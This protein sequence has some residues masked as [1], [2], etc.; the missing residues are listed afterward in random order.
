MTLRPGSARPTPA[1]RYDAIALLCLA[2]LALIFFWPVTLGHGW[3][4]RGGGDL[5]SFLWPTYTYASQSLHAGRLPLWNPTLYSGAPFAAD[6]QTS[7]FYPINLVVFLLAP[8]LPYTAMEWLVV[9][10]FWVA[11]AS[12]YFCL[13]AL[14]ADETTPAGPHPGPLSRRSGPEWWQQVRAAGEGVRGEGRQAVSHRPARRVGK[15]TCWRPPPK[16]ERPPA[17]P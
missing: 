6:N 12:M 13:R 17:T 3:I 11:G 7:L 14:L 1:W 10:H 15:N 4:P 5:A 8:T 2:L 16:S 9:F